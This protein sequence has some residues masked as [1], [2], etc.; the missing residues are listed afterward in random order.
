MVWVVPAILWLALAEDR[1][2]RGIA[3]AGATA[4]VFWSAPIWW[5]PYKDT[6]DL[7]LNGWQLAAGNAFFFALLLF[8]MGTAVLVAR[9]GSGRF[10]ARE[11]LLSGTG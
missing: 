11:Q 6:L 5:V 9:R 8:M 4:I 10:K 7:H 2:R 1:P 3:L